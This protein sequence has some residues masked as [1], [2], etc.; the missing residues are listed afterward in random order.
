MQLLVFQL[1]GLF[2][3][4]RVDTTKDGQPVG[5]ASFDTIERMVD[6]MRALSNSTMFFANNVRTQQ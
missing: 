5:I 3:S 6:A 2:L 1:D 4:A